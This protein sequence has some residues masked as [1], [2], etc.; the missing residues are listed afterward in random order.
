MF[1][2]AKNIAEVKIMEKKMKRRSYVR[3][4]S[5]VAALAAVLVT[6]S[7]CG[8]VRASKYERQITLS[9]QRALTELDGRLRE[10]GTS[11]KKGGVFKHSADA[12]RYGVG[13]VRETLAAKKLAFRASA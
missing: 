2:F 5:F 11:L 8:N 10:I 12:E 4:V 3:I 9:Q 13:A 6:A 1:F 7:I